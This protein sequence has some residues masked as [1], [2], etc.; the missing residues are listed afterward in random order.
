MLTRRALLRLISCI[1]FAGALAA[2]AQPPGAILVETRIEGYRHYD[3]PRIESTLREGDEL[4]L[5]REPQNPHDARAIAI[6]DTRGR[7]LGYLPRKENRIPARLMDQGMELT[8]AITTI[9]R[10]AEPWKRVRVALRMEK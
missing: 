10:D 3:G 5:R 7:K 8:A 2:R 4:E 9:A 1:P 6:H